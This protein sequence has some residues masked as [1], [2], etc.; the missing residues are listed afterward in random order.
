[1]QLTIVRSA[2]KTLSLHLDRAGNAVVRA[3]LR[4]PEKEIIA[5]VEKNRKWLEKRIAAR[6][7]LSVL[8]LT[9]GATLLLFGASYTVHAGK[10]SLTAGKIYLPTEEREAAF[11]RLLKKHAAA[12]MG[13]LTELVSVRSGLKYSAVRISSARGRW[14]SCNAKGKISYS[15]RV[16]FLDPALAEYVAVHELCHTVHF[17]HSAAFWKL[18]EQILPDYKLRRKELKRR[19]GV[20]NYL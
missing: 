15:F 11:V 2:R 13:S 17:N 10:S 1:M 6:Q 7:A 16:A 8:D 19:N 18:V 3:P 20:M 14:G 5:F 9:D 4:T 12:V